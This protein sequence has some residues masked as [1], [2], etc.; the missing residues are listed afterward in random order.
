MDFALTDEQRMI[1][2]TAREIVD[3][4]GATYFREK[5]LADEP[6]DAFTDEIASAGFY[7]LPLPEAY[8]GAG[9]GMLELVAVIEAI[10]EAGAWDAIGQFTLNTVFGGV[11]L[12]QY[13]TEAQKRRYLPRIADGEM[14]WAL[15]VT[16]ARAGSNMLETATTAERD[17]DE[18]VLNGEK[19]FNS[20]LD[21]ADGYTLLARTSEY[22]PTDRTHGLTVF[23]VDPD[24]EGIEYEPV[25][26][27][28]H[29]PP[30]E[31]TFTVH[32]DDLRVEETQVIGAVDE[33]VDPIFEVLNPERLSTAAEHLGRGRW[34]LDR[35]VER[36]RDRE[37]WGEPIGAHQGVQHPLAEAYADLE[38]AST[39]VR[40]GAV[41]YDNGA[42]NLGE[43]TNIGHL[44]AGRAAFAAADAAVETFGG[45][46]AVADYG[47]TAVWSMIRHQR[48]A[49]VT[50]NMK[51]NYIANNVLD[52]PRSYGT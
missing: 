14:D 46:S 43:L 21:E 32:I 44:K 37:V 23:L 41:G 7:G 34:A 45:A 18:F 42:E 39:M 49:P 48:I 10:G 5:R 12:S 29:W 31:H 25:D 36:A 22:D 19:A 4:F 8:G 1:V 11:V 30:G 52:L 51:L 50:E 16:E 2:R 6:P 20:G 33:G 38:A 28:I 27:D 47:I 9:L 26:L 35:A 24:A 15:G 13:G 40:R 3:S 17:G